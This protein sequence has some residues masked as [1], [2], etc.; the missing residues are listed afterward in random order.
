[1]FYREVNN[2]RAPRCANLINYWKALVKSFW[3]ETFTVNINYPHRVLSVERGAFC[4]REFVFHI[5]DVLIVFIF[6]HY[7]GESCN[8]PTIKIS[9]FLQEII[10]FI[11]FYEIY[12]T[13]W[14]KLFIGLPKIHNPVQLHI[15]SFSCVFKTTKHINYYRI[16]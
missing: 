1:M 3:L 8:T 12:C 13:T 14:G 15:N 6:S 16:K 10:I 9:Y 5:F 11:F 7:E 4:G 2:K